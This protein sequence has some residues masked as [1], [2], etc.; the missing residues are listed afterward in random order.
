MGLNV[1]FV[2]KADIEPFQLQQVLPSWIGGQATV[3]YEQ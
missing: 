1:C 3:P 2:P